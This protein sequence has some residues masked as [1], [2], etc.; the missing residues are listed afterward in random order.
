ME[1]QDPKIDN[2][3]Q[4]ASAQYLQGEFQAALATWR[5]LLKL[6]PE[7]DRA[8]EGVKLCEMLAEDGGAGA[9]PAAGIS[10]EGFDDDLEELDAILGGEPSAG[11]SRPQG[12]SANE[13][14]EMLNFEFSDQEE[15]AGDMP[16]APLAADPNRQMEGIDLG[17]S[18][19]TETLELGTTAPEPPEV[20]F[21]FDPQSLDLPEKSTEQREAGA[22]PSETAAAELRHRVFELLSEAQTL[23]DTGDRDGALSVLKRIFILDENNEAAVGLKGLIEA[24]CAVAAPEAPLA[25]EQAIEF[26]AMPAEEIPPETDAL[27]AEPEVAQMEE[28][29]EEELQEKPEPSVELAVGMPGATLRERL[30]GSKLVMAGGLLAVVAIGAFSAYWFM[31]GPGAPDDSEQAMSDAPSV[32]GTLPIRLPEI[33]G[34]EH[35]AE[36]AVKK[37][38]SVPGEE[39]DL[40]ALGAQADEAYR[41]GNYSDAVLYYNQL[42]DAD[43]DNRS[44]KN[45]LAEAGERYRAQKELE[46]KR[47]EAFDA[48]ASGNYRAALTIFYRMPEASDQGQLERYQRNGWYNM[49]LQA[50]AV[51][52]CASAKTHFKEAQAIDPH[53]KAITLVLDLA[54]V[55]RYSREEASFQQEVRALTYRGLED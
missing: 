53:D 41:Q 18:V 44:A 12:A 20:Q 37:N 31:W 39:I 9:D 14:E 38:D 51:G 45:K 24:E 3:Q 43:P 8:L 13:P 32:A 19:E 33:P 35:E 48:F 11:S 2:L 5:E 29:V 42:L 34:Q 15:H 25:E 4:K 1:S 47:V 27:S 50:L 55:C 26:E 46:E 28:A 7:D 6:D 30:A 22:S 36:A 16:A 23:H 17:D 54:R 21:E 52:D 49:G 10:I 40:D